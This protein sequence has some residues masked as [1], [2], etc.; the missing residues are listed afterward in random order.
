[1]KTLK[2]QNVGIL[3]KNKPTIYIG[4]LS[5]KRNE[6]G[7]INIFKKYGKVNYVRIVKDK[8]TQKSKGIAFIQMEGQ[9]ETS[10]AI[11]SLQGSQL[12]GRNIKISIAKDSNPKTK[13]MD[14]KAVAKITKARKR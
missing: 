11:H 12:D 4:N 9:Q 1:M 2:E 13:G 5:Y 6:L 14:R 10:L 7:L 3:D 8:K